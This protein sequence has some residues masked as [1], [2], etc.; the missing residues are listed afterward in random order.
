M[1]NKDGGGGQFLDFVGG[2]SCYEGRHRAYERSPP[3]VPPPPPTRE[4]SANRDLEF[5]ANVSIVLFLPL[6][7]SFFIKIVKKHQNLADI[8]LQSCQRKRCVCKFGS[9]GI[10]G[11]D[12][13]SADNCNL[14]LTGK[15]VDFKN[16]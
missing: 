15:F 6:S 10:S 3:P 11:T 13:I 12:R 2:H 5:Y 8:L 9:R 4:N 1:I 14:T 16:C 7:L